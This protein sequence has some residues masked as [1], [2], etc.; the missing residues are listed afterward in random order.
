MHKRNQRLIKLLTSILISTQILALISTAMLGAIQPTPQ[1]AQQVARQVGFS[2]GFVNAAEHLTAAGQRLW[3]APTTIQAA[4]LAA[5]SDLS[6]NVTTPWVQ[7]TF[8]VSATTTRTPNTIPIVG[9]GVLTCPTISN[10][11]N[12]T[13]V[14]APNIPVSS[15]ITAKMKS[16]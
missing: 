8:Q 11:N 16:V 15:P 9:C 6:G 3:G 2:D 12:T 7:S 5:L 4:P 13:M 1:M 10:P 14:A